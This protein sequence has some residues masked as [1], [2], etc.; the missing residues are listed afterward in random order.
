V[1][2]RSCVK[3]SVQR[4]YIAEEE[5]A[6]PTTVALELVFATA[7]IDARENREVVTIAISGKILHTINEN[8]V[9]MHM[10]GTLAELMAK[11]DPKLYRKESPL[12]V[13]PENL[14]LQEEADI[15]TERNG[16][17]S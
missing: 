12:L 10:N 9:V 2:A 14:M 11:K 3:G 1:K 5:V 7:A 17:Q 13:P 16:V 15:R 8:Y 6:L 4:D